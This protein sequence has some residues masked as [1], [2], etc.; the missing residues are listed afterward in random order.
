MAALA[1]LAG[2]VAVREVEAQGRCPR[3]VYEVSAKAQPGGDGSPAKPFATVG[4]ALAAGAKAGAC[5]VKVHIAP[6]TYAEGTLAI[7]RDTSLLGQNVSAV[8][9]EGVVAMKDAHRLS[10]ESLTLRPAKNAL[11]PAIEIGHPR[12]RVVVQTVRVLEPVTCGLCQAGGTLSAVGLEITGV[13]ATTT[14]GTGTAIS[15]TGGVRAELSWVRLAHNTHALYAAG[16]TTLVTVHGLVVEHTGHSPFIDDYYATH[17]VCPDVH[18][19]AVE[20]DA[21][22]QGTGTLWL[23]S[24]S[25]LTG[26]YAHD[27]AQVRVRDA[28]VTDTTIAPIASRSSCGGGFGVTASRTGLVD[29]RR[30]GVAAFEVCAVKVNDGGEMDLRDGT[31]TGGPMGAC[32]NASP[33]FDVCRL[34][35]DVLYVDVDIPLNGDFVGPPG[36]CDRAID[37]ITR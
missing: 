31:L 15:L 5:D 12:A 25:E 36:A 26:L 10:L 3:A 32:V 28:R 22:A 11:A 35:P 34:R 20:F 19:G 18:M 37:F 6:G 1:T 24:H 27:G 17:G 21:G 29:L 9:L 7:T 8:V 23:I 30:F 13:R 33:A 4:A 16:E 2:A 14:P